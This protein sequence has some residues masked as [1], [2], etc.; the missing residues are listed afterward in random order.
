MFPSASAASMV[1]RAAARCTTIRKQMIRVAGGAT[2][3]YLTLLP[4]GSVRS[5][6]TRDPISY[7]VQ[8]SEHDDDDHTER[9]ALIPRTE[10]AMSP[11][12]V[13]RF[14]T[15]SSLVD[16]TI[17]PEY[18]G[19]WTEKQISFDEDYD[20]WNLHGPPPPATQSDL[21]QVDGI[22]P[23]LVEYGTD[24]EA[25]ARSLF[26]TTI[27][28]GFEYDTDYDMISTTIENEVSGDDE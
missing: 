13:R 14:A 6:P 23:V 12:R 20:E 17:V 18:N 27:R 16:A 22:D 8:T 21:G 5:F 25:A 24:V 19:I 4:A 9:R 10:R 11:G 1:V 7:A 28:T 15:T 2:T 3:R 26:S